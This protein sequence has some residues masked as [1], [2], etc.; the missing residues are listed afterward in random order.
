MKPTYVSIVL[1]S[2]LA[3]LMLEAGELRLFPHELPWSGKPALSNE[4]VIEGMTIRAWMTATIFPEFKFSGTLGEAISYLMSESRAVTPGG[5]MIGGF[6]IR[7]GNANP[8]L[9][10]VRIDILLKRKNALEVI[11]AICGAAKTTWTLAPVT[12]IIGEP[13]KNATGGQDRNEA[14]PDPFAPN[15]K[16]GKG[17]PK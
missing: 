11:D 16:D 9:S 14:A 6:V 2:L 13:A 8:D 7:S 15:V 17:H 4:P 3:G 12:I 5:R 1:I 10:T